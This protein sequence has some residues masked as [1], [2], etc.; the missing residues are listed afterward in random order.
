[1]LCATG[2]LNDTDATL[3]EES[4][5]MVPDTCFEFPATD[6][7]CPR[8]DTDFEALPDAVKATVS[9]P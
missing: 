9:L 5:V 3:F 8:T 6:M 1:M 7:V 2:Y 4:K